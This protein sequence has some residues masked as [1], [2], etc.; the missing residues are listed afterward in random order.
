MTEVGHIADDLRRGYD[1]AWYGPSLEQLLGAFTPEQAAA[2][3]LPNRHSAWEVVLHLAANIDWVRHRLCGRAVELSAAEDWPA[4]GEVSAAAWGAARDRLEASHR[5]LLR[6]VEQLG[7]RQL[8][9]TVPGR[10]YP[11]HV[12]LL[13]I[14]GHNAYHAGQLALLAPAPP[15]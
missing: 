5:E 8:A 7:D 10:T 13:G 14:A 15:A 11:V 1:E 2:R 12:M 9:D 6:L 4:I 3:P